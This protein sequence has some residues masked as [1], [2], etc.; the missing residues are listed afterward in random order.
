MAHIIIYLINLC[1]ARGL[2]RCQDK[3]SC[4]RGAAC[5][6]T[7]SFIVGN[8][9]R[10]Q[11]RVIPAEQAAAFARQ[12]NMPYFECC[13]TTGEGLEEIRSHAAAIYRTMKGLPSEQGLLLNGKIEMLKSE[14]AKYVAKNKM[15]E[16][17]NA[18]AELPRI[19][20]RNAA[21]KECISALA[22]EERRL[23]Q[24]EIAS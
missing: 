5:P 17:A 7:V 13:V 24:A 19:S 23:G 10:N 15:Q 20:Q 8:R 16:Y 2:E 11:A 14:R 9:P 22:S 6:D 1:D 4:C 12:Q 18:A 21:L 3:I